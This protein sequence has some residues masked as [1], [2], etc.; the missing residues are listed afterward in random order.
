MTAETA[1]KIQIVLLIAVVVAAIR[2]GL[3]WQERR[4]AAAPVQKATEKPLNADYYVTPPR[5]YGYDLKSASAE[6][7]HKPVW[8]KVGYASAYYPER[9][10]KVDLAHSAGVLGPLEKLE[11]TDLATATPPERGT[12]KQVLAV[13]DKNGK[14]CAVPIGT[15]QD[16]QYTFIVNE[17]FFLRDPHE[18]YRH[19]PA[20]VWQAIDRHE[21]QKGMSELQV[22]FALGIGY[23][24][25]EMGNRTLQYPNGGHAVSVVYE[26]G[27]ATEVTPV[28]PQPGG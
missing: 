17:V 11:I 26:E 25:G 2:L 6:L 15:M 20:A 3:I 4:E 1:K 12:P 18:L 9:N 7:V 27:K 28:A 16:G 10:G 14:S 8:V 5:F 22:G 21:A 24:K 19:W 13:F 23:G